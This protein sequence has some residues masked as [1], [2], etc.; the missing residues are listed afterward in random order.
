VRAG[1]SRALVLRAD[2]GAGKSALLDYAVQRAT[3]FT[4]LRATGVESEKELAYSG[5]HQLCGTAIHDLSALP[6]PQAAA[7]EVALGRRSGDAPDR[8]MV[9]LA[10]LNIFA[11]AG[12]ALPLICVV[13]DAQ[14]VDS[15]SVQVLSFVA[16][17]LVAES[18][19]IVFAVRE[20]VDEA[21]AGIDDLPVPGLEPHDA[22]LLLESVAPG[23]MDKDIRERFVSE[24]RGN[25]LALIALSR[26]LTSL[27]FAGGFGMPPH[28]SLTKRI[29]DSFVRRIERLPRPA[30]L[31]LL[32]AA[33]E[34]VGDRRLHQQ[35]IET[36]G[37]DI[38]AIA[39]AIEDGLIKLGGQIEFLHPLVRSAV[40]AASSLD[41]RRAAHRALAANTNPA[42]DP[43]RRAWHLAEATL[44]LDEDVADELVRSAR[45]ARARGGMAAGAAFHARS[46]E[47]TPD[48]TMRSRRALMAAEDTFRAGG[49]TM[50]LELLELADIALLDDH[51]RARAELVRAHASS[52]TSRGRGAAAHLLFVAKMLEPHDGETAIATYSS[53]LLAALS[54]GTLAVT[55]GVSEVA[56]AVLSADPAQPLSQP[57]QAA[58]DALRGLASLI[59][60]GYNV[61]A[62]ALTQALEKL[63]A[64]ATA[65]DSHH[66]AEPDPR[67]GLGEEAAPIGG[68][69]QWM[70]IACLLARTLLNDDAYDALTTRALDISRRHGSFDRLPLLM[71]ERTSLLLFSGRTAEAG[72]LAY[73]MEPLIQATGTPTS[74]TRS[75]WIATFR[76]DESTKLEV[77]ERLRPQIS[78]RGEGQW[79]VAV[80]WQDALL[81][82][83][84]G[85]FPEA[86]TAAESAAG[87][88][89]D[90]GLAG[91]ILPE[92]IEAAVRSGALD[93]AESSLRTLETIASASGSQWARG[94]YARCEAL[95]STDD[96]RAEARY[97]DAIELLDQ[98]GIRTALARA[99][100]L[101][102][103]WL[104]RKNRRTQSRKHL[105]LAHELFVEHDS[106]GFA[107]RARRELS[108]T[109]EVVQ[110]R[111]GGRLNELTLQEHQ[112][113]TL[114]AGGRTNPEIGEQL[115]LS[116]RT[117]EWH[118]RK[119][120]VKLNVTSR[121][122]L[123]RVLQNQR[124][125]AAEHAGST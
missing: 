122:H 22:R 60:Y 51:Q 89:F 3:G 37:I 36:M 97:R 48:P 109:G 94:L 72:L 24:A 33:L 119:V 30:K 9:C 55:V 34:P 49:T 43:D 45:R 16:R 19:A 92:H 38:E 91:W 75:G 79:F 32:V 2:A 124:P 25:P 115:F 8:F 18:V 76:G 42:A 11:E 86:L 1:R 95:V 114:A 14:W 61:A 52:T 56:K 107:E 96:D 27:E 113:A 46:A 50:A 121:R 104:R 6:A 69:L 28:S 125:L 39:P 87:H 103:E 82:N 105:R 17:R 26:G 85:R 29:E 41:D 99:H 54:A 4:V 102:G 59:V 98:T 71:A 88:P 12:A 40:V 101:L 44:G 20:P 57:A 106:L 74:L 21:F 5:L 110:K 15:A 31:S 90:L 111:S 77:T 67:R 108:A 23:P 78:E 80:A 116:P 68:T 7:L 117:V 35:A 63:V 53:A 100:L 112:I 65:D 58:L 13:D 64:C 10:V 120:F 123:A 84:L 83:S 93:R 62:P 70:P 47:L 118:L 73:E 66:V 81:Y